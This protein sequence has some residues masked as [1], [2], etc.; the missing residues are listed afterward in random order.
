MKDMR[1]ATIKLWLLTDT[2]Y[3][4]TN[5]CRVGPIPARSGPISK[6]RRFGPI[7][8]LSR[9][10]L[11]SLFWEKQVRYKVEFTLILIL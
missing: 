11:I 1:R 7:L 6:V 9:F 8:D 10:S 2:Y 4:Q 3:R 5:P